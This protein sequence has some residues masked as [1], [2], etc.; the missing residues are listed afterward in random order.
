[1]VINHLLHGMILQVSLENPPGS[2]I[3]RIDFPKL[4]GYFPGYFWVAIPGCPRKLGSMVS[5]NS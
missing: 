2:S 4:G 5:Y 3:G 1:M